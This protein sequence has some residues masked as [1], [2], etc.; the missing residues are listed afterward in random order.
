MPGDPRVFAFNT[1]AGEL[2]GYRFHCPGCGYEHLIPTTGPK[3]WGFNNSIEA[4]TFTPSILVHEVKREDGTTYAP[5]CH[6]FVTD[7][8]IGYLED[9]THALAGQTVDL[10][11][12]PLNVIRKGEP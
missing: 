7:G 12:Y 1:F 6:S 11:T 8:K 4:P 3:G 5:R 10:P 9:S 2:Y